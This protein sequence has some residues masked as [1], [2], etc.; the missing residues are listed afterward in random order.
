MT[1]DFLTVAIVAVGVAGI[2]GVLM[3]VSFAEQRA[4]TAWAWWGGAY[5]L[6]ASGYLLIIMRAQLA[7]FVTIV[8]A[9]AMVFAGY[10]MVWMGARAFEARPQRAFLILVAPGIW[11][12]ACQFP[13]FVADVNPRILLASSLM[14]TLV[15]L[16]AF[17]LWRGRAEQLRARTAIII[18]FAI[19]A[20]LL[21]SRIVLT[22]LAPISN[23]HPLATSGWFM[24]SALGGLVLGLSL[25]FLLVILPRQ[26]AE[27]RYK[28]AALVDPL[29]GLPNR[30]AFLDRAEQ[31]VRTRV[32]HGRPVAVLL[33]DLDRFKEINDCYGHATGD[34]ALQIFAGVIS[35]HLRFDDVAGRLGGE[36]FAVFLPGADLNEA[37]ATGELI[38]ESFAYEAE[39]LDGRMLCATVSVG[40]VCTQESAVVVSDLLARA[41]VALYRA[42]RAGRNRVEVLGSDFGRAGF[43]S[44][45]EPSLVPAVGWVP[46]R[47]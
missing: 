42:K 14:A 24:Q 16:A 21:L 25:G 6:I 4:T 17:E 35:R 22:L 13:R 1:L 40:I 32:G 23:G 34:H 43:A 3:L 26:R 30:R 19:Y 9:N 18:L 28:T 2:I 45:Q 38:R 36:E 41:D 11:I 29:T 12:A 33:F 7:P 44:L 10:G 27:A 37:V 47:A 8:L 39:E 31:L 15:A 20:A 46:E 5:L